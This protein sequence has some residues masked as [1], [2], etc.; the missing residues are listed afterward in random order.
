ME[1]IKRAHKKSNRNRRSHAKGQ[2]PN[3]IVPSAWE[4]K[5]WKKIKKKTDE[6]VGNLEKI[7]LLY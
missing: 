5:D 7:L 6:D 2:L 1:N 3:F 4:Q